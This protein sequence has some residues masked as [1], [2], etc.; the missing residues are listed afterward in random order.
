MSEDLDK[1]RGLLADLNEEPFLKLVA[2]RLA[3]GI[4]PLQIVAACRDGMT[5]VGTRFAAQDYFVSDLLVSAEIFNGAMTMIGPKLPARQEGE[6]QAKVVFGTVQGDIHDIG[7][8][9]VVAML[10]CGGFTVYDVGI[11]TPPQVFVDKLRETGASVLGLSGLLTTAYPSM[12]AT[13]QAL[14]AANLRNTVKVMIGGGLVDDQVC[15]YVGADAWGRDA[16]EAVQLAKNLAG[17]Q[18]K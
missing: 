15:A 1:I 2:D 4:D 11:N 14:A 7:K 12:A 9:L 6:S 8:N 17:G 16:I 5:M 3:A 13:V 10:R 18:S